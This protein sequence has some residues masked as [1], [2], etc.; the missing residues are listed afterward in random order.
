MTNWAKIVTDFLFYAY[1]IGLH[2]VRI[3]VFDNYQAYPVPLND[4]PIL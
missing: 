4:L 2:Q 1:G 3:L